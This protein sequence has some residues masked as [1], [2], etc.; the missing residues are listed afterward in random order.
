VTGRRGGVHGGARLD[1]M[2]GGEHGAHGRLAQAREGSRRWQGAFRAT[3]DMV[4]FF[5]PYPLRCTR[6][7]ATARPRRCGPVKHGGG[8]LREREGPRLNLAPR[9]RHA[10]V[11]G[12]TVTWGVRLAKRCVRARM[13]PD[14]H[15]VADS[16]GN[17]RRTRRHGKARPRKWLV[18]MKAATPARSCIPAWHEGRHHQRRRGG[19]VH[20]CVPPRLDGRATTRGEKQLSSPRWPRAEVQASV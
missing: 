9:D 17:G 15:G 8:I 7:S 4:P 13:R 14:R 1:A 5:L 6:F 20:R 2:G 16:K 18:L 3:K 10:H 19:A 11:L 12:C